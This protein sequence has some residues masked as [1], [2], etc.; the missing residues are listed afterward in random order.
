C[1]AVN[2][3]AIVIGAVKGRVNPEDSND[4]RVLVNELMKSV[5]EK[6]KSEIC[7]DLK[8]SGVDCSD[9]VEFVYQE[10]DRILKAN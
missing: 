3:A 10:L 6:Y 2:A 1:G 5:K 8:K 9:I 7:L 4:A